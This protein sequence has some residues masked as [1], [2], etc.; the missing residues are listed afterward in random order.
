ME[1]T[2]FQQSLPDE[3]QPDGTMEVPLSDGAT[4][5]LPVCHPVFSTWRGEPVS[6]NYGGKAMLTY[7]DERPEP[8]FAELVILRLLQKRGWD[9]VWVEAFGGPNYLRD[10]P[11]DWALRSKHVAIPAEKEELLRKI[12]KAAK[13]CF[14]VFAWQGDQVLFCEAKL[15]RKD[16]LTAPQHRFIEAALACG[17]PL[18]SLLVAEWTSV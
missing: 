13:T 18:H 10:M 17:V 1:A 8:C 12:W 14:D 4:V 16:K 9:G 6:F 3:L 5:S 15:S 11:S 7:E 2:Q